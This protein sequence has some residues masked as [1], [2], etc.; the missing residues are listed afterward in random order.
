[1]TDSELKEIS[2]ELIYNYLNNPTLYPKNKI[3]NMFKPAITILNK[4]L[5]EYFSINGCIKSESIGEESVTYKDNVDLESLILT[6]KYLLPDPKRIF[7]TKVIEKKEHMQTKKIYLRNKE[8]KVNIQPIT[9]KAIKTVWGSEIK[10][11]W[12][13][14]SDKSLKVDDVV[15]FKN[16]SYR[17]EDKKEW[18]TSTVYALIESDVIIHD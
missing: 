12:Q 10:A 9:E 5:S 4:N 8:I 11:K 1:M 16:I 17:I 2:I 6:I 15:I 13:M 7:T 14:L 3:E 18:L